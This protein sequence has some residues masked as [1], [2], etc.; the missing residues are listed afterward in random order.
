MIFNTSVNYKR[1]D[2]VHVANLRFLILI[3]TFAFNVHNCSKVKDENCAL[4]SENCA[5]E[6]YANHATILQKSCDE[7]KKQ[8][9]HV[10]GLRADWSFV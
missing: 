5:A 6:C 1:T 10:T 2:L 7:K 4:H 9:K 3:R 8:K